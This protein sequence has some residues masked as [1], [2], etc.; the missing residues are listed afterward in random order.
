LKEIISTE[1]A[2]K[3]VGPYSQAVRAGDL[4]FVSS[5]LGLDPV[6]GSLP[7]T[8]EDQMRQALAN[9]YAILAASGADWNNVVK[10]NLYLTDLTTYSKVNDIYSAFLGDSAPARST[11]VVS[12]LPRRAFVSIDVVAY[13]A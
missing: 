13:L 7:P 10:V 5:Q 2:P 8:V 4:L 9:V 6:T 3:P 11:V 1:G 12:S